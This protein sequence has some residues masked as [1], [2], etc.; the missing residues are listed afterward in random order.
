MTAPSAAHPSPLPARSSGPLDS[1]D[2]YLTQIGRYPLLSDDQHVALAKL[3]EAANRAELSASSPTMT[4]EQRQALEATRSAGRAARRSFIEANL[5][6]VVSI[7]KRHPNPGMSMLDRIQEGNLGVVRAVEKFDH[8]RGIKFSTY[9]TWWIR[10]AIMRG[11]ANKARSIRLPVHVSD[12]VQRIHRISWEL[13]ES[14]GR[15]STIDEIAHVAGTSADQVREALSLLPPLSLHHPIGE[16]GGEVGDLLADPQEQDPF[17]AVALELARQDLGRALGSLT[18]PERTILSLRFGLLGDEP[19]TLAEAGKRF[20]MNRDAARRVQNRAMS[21]LRHPCLL[22]TLGAASGYWVAAPSRADSPRAETTEI[23]SS[24][25]PANKQR[26]TAVGYANTV[27]LEMPYE[28]AVSR[29]KE[30]FQ[31]QGFG[32]LTEID[33]QATFKK[34][35][36]KDIE[37]YLIL[38]VC[39][40]QLAHRAFQV[41]P[42]I[43][44]L[45]PCTVVVRE[46]QGK[47]LVQALDPQLLVTIPHK[48]GL[49]PIADEAGQRIQAALEAMTADP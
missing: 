23:S 22:N 36:D 17:E 20:R 12:R 3:I 43:G 29:V 18:G 5:R 42:E 16:E 24:Q 25:P 49:Q 15:P 7:A 41:D 9:A 38:G 40:P 10:E 27:A 44:M 45:L 46:S 8:R 39:N 13:T 2:L 47:T 11:I 34:K 4:A 32:L 35:L 19:V 48:D 1:L 28:D 33:L 26:R 14:F 6:L 21:K 31:A 30:A 37:R